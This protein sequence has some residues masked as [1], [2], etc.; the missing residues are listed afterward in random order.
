MKHVSANDG[1]E[2]RPAPPVSRP[3]VP[4]S[5]CARGRLAVRLLAAAWVAARAVAAFAQPPPDPLPARIWAPA[6]LA[7]PSAAT[8][9]GA[10]IGPESDLWPT[11]LPDVDGLISMPFGRGVE[12]C[13]F[14]DFDDFDDVGGMAVGRV[15]PVSAL[16][17]SMAASESVRGPPILRPPAE[18][19]YDLAG[20]RSIA[21]PL[22]RYP[23]YPPA[24]FTGSSSVIPEERQESSHFVPIE[25]RWR[26]GLKPWDRYGRGHPRLEDYPYALGNGFNPYTQNLLKEDYP[27]IGQETFFNLAV[28]SRTIANF[29]QV[30]TPNTPFESTPTP[31][32]EDFYGNPNGFFF[33]Q[34]YTIAMDLIHGDRAFKPNDWRIRIAPVVNTNYLE[35][36][37]LGVVSPDVGQG[38]R[39]SRGFATLE[40][41]WLEAK[42][43]DLSPDYDFLSI[44]GGSQPFTSDFRGFIFSDLNR[45]IRLFGTRLAN[46]DQFNLIAFDQRE[47]DTNSF[48]NSFEPRNQ[49]VI[50]AN[51]YRQ[52]FIWPGHTIQTSF[53]YDHDQATLKYD[54]NGFLVRPDPIGIATPHEVNACYAG[55]ASDGHINELNVTGAFYYAFGHDT[56]NQMALRPVDIGATMAAL[57]L[58]YSPDWIRF[59]SSFFFASGDNNVNDGKG[60]GFDGI[61][62]NTQFAGGE[63]SFWVRQQI[64]LLGTNLKNLLSIYPDLRASNKFQSQANFVNPGLQL[65]NVGVDFEVTQRTRLVTNCNFLFF[66]TT[67]TLESLVFQNNISKSIGTDLSLGMET[68]PF[69]NNNMIFR[70]GV[71]GLL[72]GNGFKAL[73]GNVDGGLDNL[74][75]AFLDL[76]VAF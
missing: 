5:P 43:A 42:L 30:P 12:P 1:P 3:A 27:I 58:S 34:Y 57:E 4:W 48:L 59:R 32:Q 41:W 13:D 36:Y 9:F 73:Y 22:F 17:D 8:A 60:G 63:F 50:I 18:N 56:L 70:S 37:E 76:E 46:R 29:R 71:S 40:E 20:E 11:P 72:V 62:D 61:I 16:D 66:D 44:R 25:D 52:D 2:I 65:Y 74:F 55:I 75:A 54:K 28:I 14:D 39:R 53:H 33:L 24:G 49:Q 64:K 21:D 26:T 38:R 47:K 23:S 7:L 10:G 19:A 45:S 31:G 15:V 69:L 6:P 35:V 67:K 68:R 51:Y